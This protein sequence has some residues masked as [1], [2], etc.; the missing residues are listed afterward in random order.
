MSI[1][2][3]GKQSIIYGFGHVLTRLANFL[4]LPLLTNSLSPN[5]YG[6][7]SII[8]IFIGFSMT[9][10]RYGM[11][12]ALMKFHI[13]SNNPKSY[14]SSILFLQL[15][16][17]IFFSF[18][19]F[20][21]RYTIEPLLIGNGQTIF[22]TYMALIIFCDILWNLIVLTLRTSE[23]ALS[24]V[25][26]N[27][28]N[29]MLTLAF[30][31]YFVNTKQLGTQGVLLGNVYAS[32]IMLTLSSFLL[33]NQFSIKEIKFSIMGEV[34]KFA[35]PF[36]PAAIFA[37][38]MEGADR[39]I[40]KYMLN[41]ATVGIYSAGYKLGIFGLLIVMGFNMGWTPY[42]LKN[43]KQKKSNSDYSIIATLLLGFYGFV[44]IMLTALLQQIQYIKIFGY[45]L[46][47][48][49]YFNGIAIAP[50]IL[51]SY[52]F[53][54]IYILMLPRIYKYNQTPKIVSFRLLGALSNIILNLILIPKF[55]IMGS[56]FSTLFSFAIMSYYI[57]NIG[58]RL[59]YIKY[60]LIGWMF[61]LLIWGG[62]I[63]SIIINNNYL[64]TIIMIILYPILWY[65]LIITSDERNALL[66][67][68]R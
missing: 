24:F 30:I 31:M 35:L 10:Y 27:L 8:Y 52:Y 7:I 59:E 9:F 55:G 1:L 47:G 67:I 62:V 40:L 34:I 20:F 21:S 25:S 65:K 64:I 5:D 66:E 32:C 50:I 19:L 43:N 18:I 4:L 36:L 16:S 53:L 44:G 13:E 56:A 63:I 41:E 23:K 14:F 37:I 15:L 39:F 46:I 29:V 17:S 38:I 42:F 51:M 48:L 57:F 6:I 22:I 60:N 33:I 3:L 49:E 11:D 28:L 61:P 12:S 58:N 2:S 26:F 45:T 54:A 68:V